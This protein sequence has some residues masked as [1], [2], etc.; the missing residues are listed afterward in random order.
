MHHSAASAGILF[1]ITAIV[2]FNMVK[3]QTG[4]GP[5]WTEDIMS[6]DLQRYLGYGITLNTIYVFINTFYA[7]IIPYDLSSTLWAIFS[8]IGKVSVFIQSRRWG[9]NQLPPREKIFF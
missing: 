9:Q 2:A 4:R 5:F 3:G 7:S 6:K 1:Q 8:G